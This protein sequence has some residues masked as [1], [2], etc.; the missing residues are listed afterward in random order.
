MPHNVP[1]ALNSLPLG[2]FACFFA[3]CCF[4]SK[5]SFLKNSFRNTIQVSNNLD[6]DKARC[7]VG[8][9]LGPNCLQK[10]SADDTR[11]QRVKRAF[12]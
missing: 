11:R 10:L 5:A 1:S 12:A 3:V 9:G 7:F 4:V 2:Y 6:P 8:P